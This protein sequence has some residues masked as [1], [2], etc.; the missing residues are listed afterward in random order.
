MRYLCILRDYGMDGLFVM[1]KT[2]MAALC[3]HGSLFSQAVC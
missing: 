3:C 1:E 2:A